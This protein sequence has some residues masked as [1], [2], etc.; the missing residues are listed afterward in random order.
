MTTFKM[1]ISTVNCYGGEFVVRIDEID[2]GA[3]I[4]AALFSVFYTKNQ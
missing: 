3:I 4:K 1:E 2:L